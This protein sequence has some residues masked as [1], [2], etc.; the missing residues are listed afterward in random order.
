MATRKRSPSELVL[1]FENGEDRSRLLYEARHL[2]NNAVVLNAQQEVFEDLVEQL[3]LSPSGEEVHVPALMCE[4]VEVARYASKLA[5]TD[6]DTVLSLLI[7][8]EEIALI[9]ARNDSDSPELTDVY[10]FPRLADFEEY[11]KGLYSESGDYRD[12]SD[13]TD[14]D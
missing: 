5:D 6:H 10:F 4:G 7:F 3:L 2:R 13:I 14:G 12:I 1:A 9:R 11:V 8:D